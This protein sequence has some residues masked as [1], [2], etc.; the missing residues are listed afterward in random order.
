MRRGRASAPVAVKPG[1]EGGGRLR[2]ISNSSNWCASLREF[3]KVITTVT[4]VEG[5]WETHDFLKR[6]NDLPTTTYLS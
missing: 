2:L 6:P 3:I 5:F 1:E 4:T